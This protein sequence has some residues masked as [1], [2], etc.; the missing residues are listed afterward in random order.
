MYPYILSRKREILYHM[1]KSIPFDTKTAAKYQGIVSPAALSACFQDCDDFQSRRIAFGLERAAGLTVCWIDGLVSGERVSEDIL[2]PLTEAS[3]SGGGDGDLAVIAQILRGSVYRCA[4]TVRTALADAA[5][6]LTHGCCV[7]LFDEAEAALSFEVRGE[8]QRAIAQPTLEKSLKGAKDSFVETLR[9]NTALV[10]QRI[11]SPQLKLRERSLGRRTH[12]RV[13]I[14]YMEELAPPAL[15]DALERRLERLDA[16]AVLATGALEE[17]IV[18]M[19]LSPFPQLLHTERPDRLAMYLLEGRVGLLIDGIPVALVLPVSFAA[20]MSVTGDASVHYMAATALTLLR[21]AALLLSLL[22]PALYVA[23]AGFHPEMIPTRLLLSI[24]EAEQKVPFSAALEV[25]GMLF[26]FGLLQEAG[27]RLPN[28]VG[29]TVSI[30]GALIVGQ[31]A[32]EARLVSPI[33]IIV[34]ALSGIGCYALPSQDMASAIRLCRLGLLLAAAAA[35]LY[36]VGLGC[37]LLLLHLSDLDSYGCNYTAPLSQSEHGLRRL[38][39][40]LPR[41]RK[42]RAAL[43]GTPEGRWPA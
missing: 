40:R 11:C 23:V 10:R 2:R 41:S 22:T 18:D 20:F 16:D 3:R 1:Y 13:A 36:G 6:D 7:L 30:I 15:L 39:L 4:V 43:P 17:S 27:L 32:V 34:V 33:S 35:G 28:P 9:T 12:T 38:L 21:W 5:D 14:L 25:L 24:I 31:A 29:D 42:R 19:P 37:C 8:G 26:A